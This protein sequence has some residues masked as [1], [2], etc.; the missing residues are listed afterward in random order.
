MLIKS[1]I[2]VPRA[3]GMTTTLNDAVEYFSAAN[4]ANSRQM[5]PSHLCNDR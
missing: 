3:Y 2:L 4:A 1:R 5:G